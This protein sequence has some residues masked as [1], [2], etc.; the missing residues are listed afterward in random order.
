M[1]ELRA[2]AQGTRLAI[3]QVSRLRETVIK[4]AAKVSVSVRRTLVELAAHCPFSEEIVL[5]AQRLSS[6]QQLI[7]S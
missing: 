4:M 2:S 1:L 5:M 6:G 7:F 3:A